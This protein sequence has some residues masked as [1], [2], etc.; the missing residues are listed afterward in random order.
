MLVELTITLTI[1]AV[2][3]AASNFIGLDT[4]TVASVIALI[5]SIFLLLKLII[6]AGRVNLVTKYLDHADSKSFRHFIANFFNKGES[7]D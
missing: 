1:T 6:I 5:L 4:T 7:N 2:I 3:V